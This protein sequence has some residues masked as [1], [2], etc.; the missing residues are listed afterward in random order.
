M[1]ISPAWLERIAAN[2]L[3]PAELE[4]LRRVSH[5]RPRDMAEHVRLP[6]TSRAGTRA[7]QALEWEVRFFAITPL[8]S[9][10]VPDELRVL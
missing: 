1:T 10:V 7:A 3:P 5:T 6:T 2:Q 8:Q 9:E 4:T